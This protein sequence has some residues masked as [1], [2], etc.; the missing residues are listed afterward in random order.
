MNIDASTF[1]AVPVLHNDARTVT[2][3]PLT[4]ET[5]AAQWAFRPPARSRRNPGAAQCGDSQTTW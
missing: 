1:V 4:L 3:D 2:V 5:A